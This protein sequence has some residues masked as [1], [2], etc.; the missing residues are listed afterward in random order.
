MNCYFGR[1]FSYVLSS[2]G[3]VLDDVIFLRYYG[4]GIDNFSDNPSLG[5]FVQKFWFRVKELSSKLN[6][7]NTIINY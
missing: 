2:C 7:N 4:L 6:N 3:I 5:L 1:S